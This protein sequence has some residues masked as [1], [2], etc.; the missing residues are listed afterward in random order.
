MVK[1]K[2]LWYYDIASPTQSWEM[3]W[4]NEDISIA[5]DLAREAEYL[6]LY[7]SR[8]IIP[9]V[10][11]KVPHIKSRYKKIFTHDMS[12][13]DGDKIIKIPPPFEPLA[14]FGESE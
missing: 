2:L 9:H 12:I 4:E 8:A 3:V 6:V 1:V 11:S 7:E 5:V 13:C 10:Y 14:Q